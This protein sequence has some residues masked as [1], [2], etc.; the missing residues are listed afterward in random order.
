MLPEIC[1]LLSDTVRCGSRMQ[2]QGLHCH[3][4][5]AVSAAF[6][7]KVVV[8]FQNP[9]VPSTQ[10]T[11]T[12]CPTVYQQDLLWDICSPRENKRSR[13]V[14]DVALKILEEATVMPH[15]SLY[16]GWSLRMYV[17]S[18]VHAGF[19]FHMGLGFCG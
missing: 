14:E 12:L 5:F 9:K 16:R 17:G 4:S 19:W 18:R 15:L 11:L 13:I 8:F 7:G 1:G 2:T 3:P 6:L 10:I